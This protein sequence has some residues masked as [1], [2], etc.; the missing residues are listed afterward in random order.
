M[1]H[2]AAW[3]MG[4]IDAPKSAPRLG[5]ATMS[6]PRLGPTTMSVQWLRPTATDERPTVAKLGP[7]ERRV[8]LQW[9]Q[10]D[11][12]NLRPAEAMHAA[13]SSCPAGREP[14]AAAGRLREAAAQGTLV[15]PGPM[16][17]KSASETSKGESAKGESA[18]GESAPG[19][20]RPGREC[21]IPAGDRQVE[22]GEVRKVKV[23]LAKDG[24]RP[25]S[26]GVPF[27]EGRRLPCSTPRGEQRKNPTSKMSQRRL[28]CRI[29][30]AILMRR[31]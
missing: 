22:E 20:E 29:P 1:L 5:P 8:P 19:R 13:A 7:T 25:S 2:L 17:G 30:I 28:R 27:I 3:A 16:S 15:D 12:S 6:A 31:S 10:N 14:A 21:P 4:G 26:A 18:Q 9:A 23:E 24:E 11:P